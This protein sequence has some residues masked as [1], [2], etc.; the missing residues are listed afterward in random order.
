MSERGLEVRCTCSRKPLLALCGVDKITREPFIHVK[1][2]KGKRLYTEVVITS[3]TAHIHCRECLHWMTLVIKHVGVS[4][5]AEP[6]PD[7]VAV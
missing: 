5:K 4:V 2:W 7:S 6:L 3:G 1:T